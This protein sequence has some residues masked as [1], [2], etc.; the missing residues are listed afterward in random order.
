MRISPRP[1][2]LAA[3]L[4]ARLATPPT[5]ARRMG[6]RAPATSPWR[7]SNN[8]SLHK[9]AF[10]R[11]QRQQESALAAALRRKG[12][13]IEGAYAGFKPAERTP[14]RAAESSFRLGNNYALH[15]S[16]FVVRPEQKLSRAEAWRAARLSP[17][18][19]AEAVKEAVVGIGTFVACTAGTLL[20][21]ITLGA[22]TTDMNSGPRARRMHRHEAELA[23]LRA[24]AGPPSLD[25]PQVIRHPTEPDEVGFAGSA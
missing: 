2:Q 16:H 20:L 6:S 3:L 7:A 14:P 18:K 23:R 11:E 1:P 21:G 10:E 8:W 5:R 22:Y 4:R 15:A 25:G 9:A 24:A 19:A 12:L 13:A 17:L